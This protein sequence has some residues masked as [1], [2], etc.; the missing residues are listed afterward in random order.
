MRIV[1]HLDGGLVQ[2]IFSEMSE[3]IE[4]L[5][6]DHDTDSGNE[7]DLA[8]TLEGSFF[9]RI[10]TSEVDEGIVHDEF[11]LFDAGTILSAIL[12]EKKK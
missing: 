2:S 11:T 5:I 3:P 7:D 9:T 1:I 12:P 6:I 10:E 4:A 8:Q